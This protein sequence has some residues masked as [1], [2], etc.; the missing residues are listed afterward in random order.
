MSVK[1]SNKVPKESVI[2]LFFSW[3]LVSAILGIL[4]STLWHRFYWW[5]IIPIVVL[6]LVFLLIL[7]LYL[8]QKD[9]RE[10]PNCGN[11]IKGKA[12]FCENCGSRVPLFC[13]TCNAKIKGTPKFCQKCGFSLRGEDSQQVPHSKTPGHVETRSGY[14]PSCGAKT[15]SSAKYCPLCG[16]EV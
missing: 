15:R 6:F 2:A 4:S 12:D 3:L 10:C 11:D 5:E 9:I 14:C 13:P 16:S 1:K 8:V 7:S